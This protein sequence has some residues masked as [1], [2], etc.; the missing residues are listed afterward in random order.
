MPICTLRGGML[1]PRDRNVFRKF[2][3]VREWLTAA[4]IQNSLTVFK[5]TTT[6]DPEQFIFLNKGQRGCAASGRIYG[7][8]SL[9]CL[10]QER[11]VRFGVRRTRYKAGVNLLW[12]KTLKHNLKC[13]CSERRSVRDGLLDLQSSLHVFFP[14]GESRILRWRAPLPGQAAPY[15]SFMRVSSI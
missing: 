15:A 2:P 8:A 12:H 6:Q 11:V 13:G 3:G 5:L 14:F 1:S 9:A 10:H 4:Q 7:T